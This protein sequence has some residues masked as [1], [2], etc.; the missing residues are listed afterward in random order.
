MMHGQIILG[1]YATLINLN[2]TSHKKGTKQ[3]K[4]E[5]KRHSSYHH[6]SSSAPSG[7]LRVADGGTLDDKDSEA[8]RVQAQRVSISSFI[9]SA[10]YSNP[11]NSNSRKCS[12]TVVSASRAPTG[13]R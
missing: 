11:Y 12:K 7:G 4:R 3:K 5:R 9:R 6:Y 10:L 13:H 2:P 1:L 8:R